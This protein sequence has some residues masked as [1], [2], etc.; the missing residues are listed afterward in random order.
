MKG[1]SYVVLVLFALMDTFGYIQPVMA[2]SR[3]KMSIAVLEL[4]DQGISAAEA[5]S[6][7]ERLRSELFKTGMFEV[8]ERAKMEEVLKEQGFQQT[9]ACATTECAVEVGRLIGVERMVAGSVGKVGA[10][11]SVDIR[12]INVE[13]GA[14]MKA[15][16]RDFTGRIDDLLRRLMPEVARELA[17]LAPEKKGGRTG[18][19]IALGVLAAGG[20]VAAVLL[21]TDKPPG[22]QMPTTGSLEVTVQ[23]P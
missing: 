20:G 14:I 18:L 17:G 3:S 13:T 4:D 2:Q 1:V 12:T 8:L 15:S 7:T 6:L 10:T 19:W 16:T 21:T 22:P 11:F 5:G 9:G 23:V